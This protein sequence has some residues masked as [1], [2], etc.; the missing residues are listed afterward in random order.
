M[1]VQAQALYHNVILLRSRYFFDWY[2]PLDKIHRAHDTC[3][4]SE[5]FRHTCNLKFMN[6]I[7]NDLF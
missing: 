1:Y 3:N 5:M 6:L 7:G 2:S 4:C